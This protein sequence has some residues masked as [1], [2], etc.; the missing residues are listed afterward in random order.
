M[1]YEIEP[2]EKNIDRMK[3]RLRANHISRLQKG[4]CSIEAGFIWSD[5]L[6]E[7]ERISGHCTN[8]AGCIATVSQRRN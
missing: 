8:I 2:M 7:L 6:T 4:N 3:E 5:I 1:A